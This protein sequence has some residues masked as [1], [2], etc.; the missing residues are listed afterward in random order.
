VKVYL[1]GPISGVPFGNRP[2][3]DDMADRLRANGFDPI[4]PH[5]VGD[6]LFA[7]VE[8]ASTND[9]QALLDR[10]TWLDYMRADIKAMM[11]ADA[12]LL[13]P[14]WGGSRGACVENKL[15]ALLD[16]PRFHELADLVAHRKAVR[17]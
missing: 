4:N 5:D 15:A 13:L 14:G 7:E 16:V 11:D 10:L 1:S 12:I 17:A 2:A 8:Q 6:A 3:F 9:G